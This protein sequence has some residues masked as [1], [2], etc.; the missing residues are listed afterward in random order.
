MN[1]HEKKLLLSFAR[2]LA[3]IYAGFS[4]LNFIR[5]IPDG[6][7]AKT[8]GIGSIY[9]SDVIERFMAF[10]SE[11]VSTASL[12]AI[13]LSVSAVFLNKNEEK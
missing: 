5:L 2:N 12:V 4:A 1:I 6:I 3:I 11:I 7:L 8:V 13:A 10:Q 9:R